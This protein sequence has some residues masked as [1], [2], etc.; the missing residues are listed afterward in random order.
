[1]AKQMV[2]LYKAKSHAR[3]YVR[4]CERSDFIILILFRFLLIHC[5]NSRLGSLKESNLIS[6]DIK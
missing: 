6:K 2:S 3:L 5:S 4:N 1:M